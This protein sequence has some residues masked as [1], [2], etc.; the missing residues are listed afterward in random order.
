DYAALRQLADLNFLRGQEKH[1]ALNTASVQPTKIWD[2]AEQLPVKIPAQHRRALRLPM[3][4]EPLETGLKLVIQVITKRT[5]TPLDCG[6]SL[7]GAWPVFVRHESENLLFP[8]GPY[9]KHVEEH[10]AWNYMGDLT[11]LKDGWNEITLYNES[12]ETLDLVGLELGIVRH[13]T[14]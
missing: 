2:V 9:T 8:A 4:T 3:C 6:V 1:Y 14:S 11:A 7:N 5:Q 12:N 13:K 10:I